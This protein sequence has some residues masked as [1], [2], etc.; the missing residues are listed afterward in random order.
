MLL[1]GQLGWWRRLTDLAGLFLVICRYIRD[2][3]DE[4]IQSCSQDDLD[5]AVRIWDNPDVCS[6]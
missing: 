1:F 6:A 2:L 3:D 4:Q 5:L